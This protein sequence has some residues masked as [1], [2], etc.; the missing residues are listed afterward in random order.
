MKYR[1][2]IQLLFAMLLFADCVNGFGSQRKTY[3]I[4]AVD[5]EVVATVTTTRESPRVEIVLE[6]S[7]IMKPGRSNY[8]DLIEAYYLTLKYGKSED[9]RDF[10][11]KKD[12][13]YREYYQQLTLT[14]EEYELK[15][16]TVQDVVT[17]GNYK[18]V[19]VEHAF[20][21]S[22]IH[23]WVH[24]IYCSK[25]ECGFSFY[26]KN[27]D[28]FVASRFISR[29]L[30]EG[31]IET[32][33]L[34]D[35]LICVI[36]PNNINEDE[37][38]SVNTID[39]RAVINHTENSRLI[40]ITEG[41]ELTG[42][43]KTSPASS[44]MKYLIRVKSKNNVDSY[45]GTH[46]ELLKHLLKSGAQVYGYRDDIESFNYDSPISISPLIR[47]SEKASQYE[48]GLDEFIGFYLSEL[49]S[50][51]AV[52]VLA[53]IE[54]EKS[55]LIIFKPFIGDVPGVTQMFAVGRT[56]Y[57]KGRVFLRAEAASPISSYLYNSDCLNQLLQNV[58]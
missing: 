43:G 15:S 54:D 52:K 8:L 34:K 44:L 6:K 3:M 39:V 4:S 40:P 16:I 32:Q 41:V 55:S 50:W 9:L 29:F 24:W 13:S 11:T 49:R 7:K 2:P 27:P 51:D 25:G 48:Y 23:H 31:L 30:V 45:T 58:E 17:W 5:G 35:N 46:A 37:Y 18:I 53:I 57:E 14:N 36:K 38:E 12:N 47:Y 22:G 56:G 21:P 20:A 1:Y 26:E 10:F 28:L 33:P 42:N 19:S